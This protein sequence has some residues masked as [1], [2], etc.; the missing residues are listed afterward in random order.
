[1]EAPLFKPVGSEISPASYSPQRPGAHSPRL[2]H[3]IVW[4]EA[5]ATNMYHLA[6]GLYLYATSKEG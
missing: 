3:R 5:L 1:M 4:P 6:K 2:P